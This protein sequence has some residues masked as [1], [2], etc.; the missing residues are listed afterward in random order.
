MNKITEKV[1]LN[2]LLCF[3]LG[4]LA[5][6]AFVVL[7]PWAIHNAQYI[8]NLGERFAKLIVVDYPVTASIGLIVVV[9]GVVLYWKFK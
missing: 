3:V 1:E 6:L 8:N 2:G 4:F 5:F 7:V 9:L